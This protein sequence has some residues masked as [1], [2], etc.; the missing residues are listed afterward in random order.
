[1]KSL[2]TIAQSILALMLL[3]ISSTPQAIAAQSA[4]QLLNR[5]VAMMKSAESIT[6]TFTTTGQGNLRGTLTIAGNKFSIDSPKMKVWYDGKTQW[7]WSQDAGEVNITEPTPDELAQVNPYAILTSLNSRYKASYIGNPSQRTILLKPSMPNPT[8]TRAEVT[9]GADEMP[10][11]MKLFFPSG[12]IMT[13]TLTSVKTGS[14]LPDSTFRFIT[15][16]AP[17]AEIIDLR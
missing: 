13:I 1:M 11:R 10:S 14:K 5:A 2:K 15:S 6:A 12:G 3:L 8:V 9:F 7:T 17:G 16:K 4:L